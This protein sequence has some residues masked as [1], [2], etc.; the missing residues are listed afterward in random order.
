[1]QKKSSEKIDAR[2]FTSW[3]KFL[4]FR[5]QQTNETYFIRIVFPTPQSANNF[6]QH[7]EKTLPIIGAEYP[8]RER[9][10]VI[11]SNDQ[12]YCFQISWMQEKGELHSTFLS[13]QYLLKTLRADRF[14][15]SLSC[16]SGL[17][18]GSNGKRYHI[19]RP[20]ER[21]DYTL[22]PQGEITTRLEKKPSHTVEEK[23]DYSQIQSCTYIDAQLLVDAFGFSKVREGK[24]YGILTHKNDALFSRLLVRD[25]GTVARP[26]DFNNREE[27]VASPKVFYPRGKFGLFVEQNSQLRNKEG[28]TN[29]ILARLRFNPYRTIVVICSDT[30]ESRL[31]AYH[32]AQELLQEFREYA[33]RNHLKVN[34][35]FKIPIIFYL[36][37]NFFG[38]RPKLSF[39]TPKMRLSD[40]AQC[41]KIDKSIDSR[42]QKI[43]AKDYEFLLGLTNN[44]G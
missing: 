5:T 37:V 11:L 1:M 36:P 26:F 40:C 20:K 42:H 6:F 29:E 18:P 30:L 41:S 15:F 24:L 39:Y 17:I 38:W 34:P 44:I 7:L 9:N 28:G 13:D 19:L 10:A 25:Y 3:D 27:A 4:N 35:N 31:L 22:S 14:D 32:F 33:Q 23:M 21:T 12:F 16:K 2:E 43:T 8:K